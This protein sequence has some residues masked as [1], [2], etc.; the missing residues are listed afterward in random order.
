MEV[1]PDRAVA[2][3]VWRVRERVDDRLYGRVARGVAVRAVGHPVDVHEDVGLADGRTRLGIRS[4]K[5]SK[6]LAARSLFR[7]DRPVTL[8]PQR[9]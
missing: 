5:I 6:R 4:C 1:D 2:A 9:L 8:P 7:S 3:D